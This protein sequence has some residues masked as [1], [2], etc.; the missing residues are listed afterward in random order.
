MLALEPGMGF[1]HRLF[2]EMKGHS[3]RESN[4]R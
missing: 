4:S 1:E 2:S 3:K